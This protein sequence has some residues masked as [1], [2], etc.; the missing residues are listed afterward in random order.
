MENKNTAI[1][2]TLLALI[3]GLLLGYFFGIT[4]YRGSVSNDM[5]HEEMDAHMHGEEEG[6]MYDD[7]LV[8]GD[9]ELQHMMDEMMLIGRG[10]T[11][12]AYEEAWLR[13]MIVHHLGAVAMSERLLE[14]TDRPELDAFARAI[15]ENQSAEIE[16][17]KTW[18]QVWFNE[19]Q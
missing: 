1:I 18:L 9:G 17:M 5:M 2:I 3:V 19:N 16:Q 7:E 13:G 15:I 10:E 4:S 12:D 14:E 6:H 8:R 11:G